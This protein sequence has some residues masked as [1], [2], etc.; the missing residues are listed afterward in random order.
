MKAYMSKTELSYKEKR[1]NDTRIKLGGSD[2]LFY[3]PQYVMDLE[4]Q[5]EKQKQHIAELQ[6]KIDKVMSLK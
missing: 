4:A 3:N 5:T 6:S 2:T 1:K